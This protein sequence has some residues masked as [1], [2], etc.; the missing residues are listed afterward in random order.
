[1]PGLI[2]FKTVDEMQKEEFDRSAASQTQNDS[3]ITGLSHHIRMVWMHNK[4]AKSEIERRMLENIRQRKGEYDPATLAKIKEFGGSD[5]FIKLTDIKCKAVEGWLKDIML[6]AGDRPWGIEPTPISDIRP[7]EEDQIVQ[8]MLA[9]FQALVSQQGIEQGQALQAMPELAEKMEKEQLDRIQDQAQKD[10]LKSELMVEDVLKEAGFYKALRS[11]IKDI[12][13]YPAV[14]M[15][16]PIVENENQLEWTESENGSIP[17]VVTKPKR[18]YYRIS[19]FDVYPS[20]GA[21]TCDDGDLIVKKRFTRS[22]LTRFKGVEGFDEGSINLVLDDFRN[23]YIDWTATDSERADI[24]NNH[25]RQ[26]NHIGTID[27]LKYYGS[28]QG[29]LLLQWGMSTDEVTDPFAEYE[30]IAYMINNVVISARINPHPLKKRGI[31]STSYSKSNDS[32]WGESVVDVLS[33]LQK[34]CNGSV[35]ALVNNMGMCAGPQF[36]LNTDSLKPGTDTSIHPLKVWEFT[37]Q[38]LQSGLPMGF[39]QPESYADKLIAIY[40]YFFD[41]ASEITGIPSYMYGSPKVSGAGSTASGLAMLMEAAGKAMKDV[42]GS[43]DEDII[44]PTVEETW[45]HIM[46]YEP[47]KAQGDIRIVARAS[48]YLIQKETLQ[49]RRQEFLNSTNNPTDMQ[50]IGVSGRAEVLREVAGGLKLRKNKI[51]PEADG[52]AAQVKQQEMMNIAQTIANTLGVPVEVIIQAAQG[53]KIAQK[54]TQPDGSEAG[55]QDARTV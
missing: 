3:M 30:I 43:I 52:L 47:E 40:K 55:G 24:T 23:G 37:T 31:F 11:V 33:D 48:D 18:K 4:Q 9:E 29:L 49:V 50:I 20:P 54:N 25:Q 10:A 46:I 19:P 5:A 45:I 8:K 15:E 12:P 41:Q 14:F 17:T 21:V 7:E 32:I 51:V 13:T 39:F 26:M 42:V 44:V 27:A 22:D 38:E 36:W 16:G 1:M 53:Q 35:R 34:I 6:P 28:V 2:A